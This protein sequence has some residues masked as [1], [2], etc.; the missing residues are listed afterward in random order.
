M[1]LALAES[2]TQELGLISLK[3]LV[4]SVKRTFSTTSAMKSDTKM[5]V[6]VPPSS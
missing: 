5:N 2:N 3:A 1:L 4:N 6:L